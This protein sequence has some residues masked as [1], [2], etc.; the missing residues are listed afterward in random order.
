MS[1][2]KINN[3]KA[4]SKRL[5]LLKITNETSERIN[6]QSD[7]EMSVALALTNKN[8][9]VTVFKSM[10]LDLRWFNRDQMKFEDW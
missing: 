4:L 1:S 10:V 8:V 9:Q 2:Y 7:K 3:I 6:K 5:G